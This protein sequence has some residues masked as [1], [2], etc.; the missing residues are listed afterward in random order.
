VFPFFSILVPI[1]EKNVR[2]TLQQR[3]ALFIQVFTLQVF[4]VDVTGFFEILRGL[5]LSFENGAR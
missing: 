4:L 3:L 2:I 5:S 1:V